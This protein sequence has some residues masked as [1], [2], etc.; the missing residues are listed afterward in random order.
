[1]ELFGNYRAKVVNNR[2]VEK[3]GRVL[4]YIPDIMPLIPETEGLW[5]RPANN[6]L[7]GRNLE[8][9][10]DCYYMGSSYIPRTGAWV[11][12][13]FEAGNINRPYYWSGLDLENTPVLPENQLGSNYQDKWTIFKSHD[14]RAVIV[15]DDDDDERVEITGKKRLITNP[16]TGDT[17]SV[18]RIDGNQTT[19]LFD[20]RNGKEKILIRTRK[21][22]FFHI[23]IDEQKLQAFF[24]SDILIKT[25][26]NLLITATENIDI[27][28][29]TGDIFIQAESG[30]INEKSAG[31]SYRQSGNNVH[32]KAGTNRYEE[33][34]ANINKL[35]G[36][37]INQD[38]AIIYDQSGGAQPSGD[39]ANAIDANPKGERNT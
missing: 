35:A 38:G 15:S 3:Y 34:G 33:A 37:N 4:V 31:D 16:P 8:G 22:D 21:G 14:G 27:K 1:M 24:E 10:E 29:K 23:D 7:G 17:A 13:F 28:S 6:P 2:D 12:V 25:N 19:I 30:E 18:Y 11:W 26:A 20:E 32:T 36:G 9:G 5:A 39:S